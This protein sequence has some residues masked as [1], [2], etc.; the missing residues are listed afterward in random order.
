[1]RLPPVV[2]MYKV[3]FQLNT[4]NQQQRDDLSYICSLQFLDVQSLILHTASTLSL[5]IYT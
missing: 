5:V 3:D 2:I 4:F 1:M